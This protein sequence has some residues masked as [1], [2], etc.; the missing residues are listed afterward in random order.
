MQYV[1][2]RRL[3][4]A[5]GKLLSQISAV[6]TALSSKANSSH[7]HG[8]GDISSGTL[9]VARGGTGVSANP[10]MLVNLGSGSAASVFGTSPRPG[11]TGTLP[12]SK[13]GTGATTAPAALDALGAAA[14]D[15]THNYAG[16]SSPGGAATSAA[17]L[18]TARTFRV[19]LASTSTASFDGT[20]NA[21]PGVSG[22]LPVANGGTGATSAAAA[23]TA[24]GISVYTQASAFLAAH[25]VGSIYQ[26]T[27]GTSPAQYG[28]TWKQVPSLGA[29]TWER[30][31]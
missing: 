26:S 16:S 12:V 31:A 27:K 11:V 18:S 5:I 24:L 29:Y 21:T 25:P 22:T 9:P 3:E 15:H 8:A 2:P 14:S 17:K 23:R 19:N 30:T 1:S 13:G 28:G 20:A 4:Y 7:T 10:S 6:R